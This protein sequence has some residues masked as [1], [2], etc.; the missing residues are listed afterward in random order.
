MSKQKVVVEYT[1]IHMLT[2]YVAD[3]YPESGLYMTDGDLVYVD[4]QKQIVTHIM[5][6]SVLQLIST[7][8]PV[9]A[10]G[11]SINDVKDIIAVT[12]APKAWLESKK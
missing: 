11:I 1:P 5:T 6:N 3:D 9:T 7:H 8:K 12:Q 2:S 10:T 4:K